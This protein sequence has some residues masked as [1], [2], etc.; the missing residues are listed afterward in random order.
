[1]RHIPGFGIV[2][3]AVPVGARQPSR[4]RDRFA[5]GSDGMLLAQ[6]IHQLVWHRQVRARGFGLEGRDPTLNEAASK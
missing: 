2:P 6:Q 4:Q 1:M 3:E 5:E